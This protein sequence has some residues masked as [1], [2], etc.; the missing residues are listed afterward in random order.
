MKLVI[1]LAG[2]GSRMRPHTWT[3]PKPLINV[4][5][6]P[7]LAHLLDK[8]QDLEIDELIIIYGWLGDQIIDYVNQHYAHLN[9]RFAEQ[10]ELRG[11]SHALWQAREWLSGQG[12]V[13]YVDTFFETDLAVV[14]DAT[15]DG[16]AFVKEVED[17]RRFGVV[18]LDEN[19]YITRFIEKPTSLENKRVVI[20]LYWLQDLSWLVRCIEA[21]MSAGDML[22]GEYFLADAFQQMVNQG[23]E[24]TTH[25]V[26]VWQDTGKPETTLQ[27]N[28]YLLDHGCDNSK[29]VRDRGRLIVP[30]CHIAPDVT[31]EN[32][33]VGPYVA[34][35]SGAA[36]R[37]AIVRDSLIDSD[38]TVEDIVI[39]GSLIGEKAHVR[40]R[41]T[42]LNIGN[43]ATAG[44]EY[45]VDASWQ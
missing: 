17:P 20:G 40:G 33:V 1:P 4:A 23:A 39:E 30:P 9:P 28:R 7:F 2:F 11:Q 34:V 12:F 29:K 26:D 15:C 5:G 25:D 45:T 22:D 43:S 8:F 10:N 27:A 18:E 6:K 42:R 35:S 32:A 13:V 36:I 44:I 37:N 19:G 16:I 41:P 31:I 14:E 38:A 24:I 3:K 21:Q